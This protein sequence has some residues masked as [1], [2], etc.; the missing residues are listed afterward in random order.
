[1]P[2]QISDAP[3]AHELAERARIRTF[4]TE[5]AAVQDLH[6]HLRQVTFRGGDL[7]AFAPCGPDTFLYLLLPPPGGTE[8]GIDQGFTWEQHARMAPEDQP[9]GAYYTLRHW[10]PVDE[11]VDILIVLHGDHGAASAWASRA[12]PGDRVALWGPRTAYHPPAGTDH[13]VLVADE[14]GLPAVAVILEQLPGDA[15]ATVLVE[16]AHHEERIDLR[17]APNI[18]I[19]WL[20]RD[21]AHAGT[22]DLLAVAVAAL[23]AFP[24]STYVWGG[25]ESRA[26]TRVRRHVRDERGLPQDAVSLVAYWRHT[27]RNA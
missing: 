1:V 3:V 13:Y 18:D 16:V 6:P 20:S 19:T 15:R 27:N 21:G 5:V 23:P 26:M 4:L 2:D 7:A 11:E 9:V 24:S 25:G 22:T 12:Q 8:L 10:R 14:T 17:A